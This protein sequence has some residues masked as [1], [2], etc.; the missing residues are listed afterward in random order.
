MKPTYT[1][2]IS[3]FDPETDERPVLKEYQVPCRD[4]ESVLGILLYIYEEIDSTLFFNYGCRYRSCGKCAIKING[5]PMLACETPLADGMILEPLDHLPVLRDL[6]VDRSG[7]LDSLKKYDLLLSAQKERERVVQPSE[8]FELVRCNECLSC[9]SICP[10]FRQKA[11]Y[12]GPFFGVKLALLHHDAREEN[13]RLSQ[14]APFLEKCIQCKQCQV[15]CPWNTLF[16]K[17]ATKI[18]GELFTRRSF[19][20]RDWVMSRPPVISY[21]VSL[22][23]LPVNKL[24]KKK[25][26]R[27]VMDHL[28]EID[29]R[30]PFPEYRKMTIK[31]RKERLEERKHQVAYF[32]GCYEKFNDPKIARA[33]LSLLE[34]LGVG[35]QVLDFGCCGGPFVGIGDLASA[36]KR[37]EVVSEELS[38]WIQ[39]GYDIVLSCTSCG[40][41]IRDDYPS[42]FRMLA[43]EE[44]QSHLLNIGEYLWQMHGSGQLKMKF[45]EIRKRIGYQAPC[46]LKA[47]KIGVP[48]VNLLKLIPGLRVHSI[49]DKCCGMAGTMGFKK[50][51]FDL[52]QKIG[53][54]LF[55]E[56]EKEGLD[57]VLSDCAACQMKMKKETGVESFHPII[58]LKEIL[59]QK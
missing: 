36:R 27:K 57:L 49:L 8:F 47:Q 41:M 12:D 34:G 9:L 24:T 26:V 21:L 33:S 22:L 40:S 23:P 35:V 28:M 59:S 37:A 4:Q 6:A 43:E 29:E 15:T 53:E 31:P 44:F 11:G 5:K 42:L 10:A 20:G 45:R 1:I 54:P 52:S 18:K 58:F 55:D 50:E 16:T 30:A 19:S 56:I 7:L 13:D 46:H 39:K 17:V 14:L 32:L 2:K 38:K 25:V 51:K 3:R 48:F